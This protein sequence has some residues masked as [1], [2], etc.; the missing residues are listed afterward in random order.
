M[1]SSDEWWV[2]VGAVLVFGSAVLW[3]SDA[4][5]AV[6]L[7]IAACGVASILVGVWRGRATKRVL[8]VGPLRT[9]PIDIVDEALDDAGY[10]VVS[11]PGPGLRA[12]PVESHRPC[13]IHGPVTGIV[14]VRDPG[15]IDALPPCGEALSAPAIAVDASDEG[16]R[17]FRASLRAS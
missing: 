4:S 15:T 6:V 3:G 10:E 7:G 8:V 1:R 17:S 11:C 12:C 16:L 13:P 14:I 5:P 9:E 2:Y